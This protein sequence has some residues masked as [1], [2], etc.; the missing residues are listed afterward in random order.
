MLAFD[1]IGETDANESLS[2]EGYGGWMNYGAFVVVAGAFHGGESDGIQ[3]AFAY[4]YGNSPGTSPEFGA[5]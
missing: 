2:V 4:S 3:T 1:G 5:S